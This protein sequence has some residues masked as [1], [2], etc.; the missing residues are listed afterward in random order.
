ILLASDPMKLRDRID[1]VAKK[2]LIEGYLERQKL[3]WQDA[4]AHMLDLQYHDSRPDKGLY[5]TLERQGRMQRICS[6][7]EINGAIFRPPN[8]TRA[9][10]RGEC[11]RRYPQEVFGVNWD[12]I[13]FGFGDEPVKRIMMNEPLKGTQAH[14]EEL[15]NKSTNAKELL[16]NMG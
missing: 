4:K 6:D 1:W 13:S 8:D 7:D 9:F 14:V 10:F 15:L 12:S 2:A 5:F 16:A 11:L 3:D